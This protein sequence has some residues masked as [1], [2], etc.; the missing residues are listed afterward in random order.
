M[1]ASVDYC[2]TSIAI[3]YVL[4]VFF[5]LCMGNLTKATLVQRLGV[6]A[7]I[8]HVVIKFFIYVNC[9]MGGIHLYVLTYITKFLPACVCIYMFVGD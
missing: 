7:Q 3:I 5:Q 8:S 9:S 1:Y 4:V 6:L 2:S